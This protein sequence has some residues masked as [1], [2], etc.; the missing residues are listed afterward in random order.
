MAIKVT[1]MAYYSFHLMIRGVNY[2]QL[3][4][5][6]QFCSICVISYGDSE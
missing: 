4:E 3:V 6:R 2:L 5:P 1:Q